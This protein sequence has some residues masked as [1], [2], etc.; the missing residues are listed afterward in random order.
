MRAG[1]ALRAYGSTVAGITIQAAVDGLKIGRILVQ[2]HLKVE[3]W[4]PGYTEQVF[5][6]FDV[7]DAVGRSSRYGGKYPLPVRGILIV[8]VPPVWSDQVD[9]ACSGQWAFVKE[10]RIASTRKLQ[11]AV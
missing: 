1:V 5:P 4:R 11:V 7:E 8:Q 2:T 3:E 9:H 10:I 6:E